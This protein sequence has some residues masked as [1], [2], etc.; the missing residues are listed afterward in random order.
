MPVGF[1][2]GD[3]LGVH[4]VQLL[5]ELLSHRLAQRVALSAREV[6]YFAGEQHDLL[7]VYGDAVGVLEVL[8]HAREIVRYG[9][10]AVLSGDEL[11]N[12][13]HRARAVEGVHGDEVL[14]GG[15]LQLAQVLL[16]ADGLKLERTHRA[17]VAVELV[18]GGVFDVHVVDVHFYAER[19]AY[20]FQ[21]LLDD[22]ERL[23]SE[24]VHLYEARFLDDLPLI[25]RAVQL[26]VRLLVLGCGDGH[27][28][29]DVVAA[30][31]EAAGV[32]ARVAHVAFQHLCVADGV[33]QER[34]GRRFR[35][36]Q[37]GYRRDGVGEVELRRFPVGAFGQFVWYQLAEAV[38]DVQRQLL[39]A[40]HVLERELRGHGSVGDDVRHVVL[41]VLVGDPLQH[42]AAPVVVEVHVDIGERDAVRVEETLEKQVV[43]Y[44]VNLRYAQTVSH[45]TSCRRA[46]PRAYAHVQLLAG[47][48][49]IVLHNEEVARETHRLHDVQFKLDAFARLLVKRVAVAACR[50]LV[51][52]LAEVVGFKLYAVELIVSSELLYLFLSLFPA[53][54]HVA[55]LVLREL[56][57]EVFLRK[58]FAVFVLRAEVL[59]YGEVGHDGGVV[60][61]VGLYFVANF[62]G[63]GERV[64][65]VGEDFVHL[66]PCL[67]P[68]L[69]RVEHS[70]F[71]VQVT[72]CRQAYKPVVRLGVFFV[73]KVAVVGADVFYAV[74]LRQAQQ[75]CVY[76]LLQ[77]VGIPVGAYGGVRHLVALELEV[78]VVSEDALE[79]QHRLL[80]FLHPSRKD[81]LRHFAAY[82]RR[83][84]DEVFVESLEV[85][86]VGARPHVEAVHPGSRNEF[87]EVVVA[88]LVLGK[89][90]EVPAALVCFPVA[91]GLVSP[92]RHVH[93]AAEDGLERGLFPLFLQVF[94]CLL[95]EL[96]RR[97]PCVRVCPVLVRHGRKRT[98]VQ[99]SKFLLKL[100]HVVL[101]LARY[102][103]GVVEELLDA[104]HIP[105][106]RHRHSAHAVAQGF[107]DEARHGSLAVKH[108]I[109]GVYVEVD[110]VLHKGE[111]D[112]FILRKVTQAGRSGKA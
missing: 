56:V 55:V 93:F 98:L 59:G 54:H 67:E 81:V 105:V 94:L 9:L 87:D 41:A 17:P 90:D 104:H 36:A 12:V 30:D 32:H 53:H 84:Y 5:D 38:A 19:E 68:F 62:A 99:G 2:A 92:P 109:L 52:Q 95:D 70:V 28:V 80:G 21:S 48:A 63:G 11:R 26:F 103:V 44:G 3:K 4:V 10:F 107:V 51:R 22:G 82:A 102:F 43:F 6:C 78:V 1:S 13:L 42:A 112:W 91:Q 45:G 34:V 29:G 73:D 49:D 7:L 100:L 108:G 75:L 24:E 96:F 89:H 71:V 40:C 69:L 110:E 74:L 85:L 50:S 18:S 33:A 47:G 97:L 101:R 27:P 60:D 57:E 31:D 23:Q 61:G 39:H 111:E 37:L 88:V 8:L 46:A 79:P 14:E 35:L 16:H 77:R 83:A 66:R 106:V 58:P 76:F 86:V 64:G 72:P 20:V 15:G 65:Q 25:L